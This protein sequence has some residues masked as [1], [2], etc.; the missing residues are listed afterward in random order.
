MVARFHYDDIVYQ[1]LLTDELPSKEEGEVSSHI[2]HCEACQA[3]LEVVSESGI[4]WDDVREFLQPGDSPTAQLGSTIGEPSQAAIDE[5]AGFNFLQ[6]SDDASSLGRFGR[7]EITE[8]LGRGGMGVVMRG[9]DPALNRHSAIKVLAPELASHAAA[10]SR[11]SREAKSAAAVVHE[12]VVP[13][14]TVDEAQGLPYLV[15]PVVEGQSLEKRVAEQGPMQVN[16][17]LRI[18]M[19]VASGLAAAHAQGLVHRD[20][21]PANIL[22]ENGVERVM[23]TDFGLARAADD[24]SMTRSG[25]IA[26]TPQYMSPEQARG[27]EIDHRSDLFSLGCVMYYMCIG[28]SPFRAETT[29]GVLHRIVNDP[30]RPIRSINPDVPAWLQTIIERLLSKDV[31]DRFQTAEEVEKLLGAW[32]AHRQQPEKVEAPA[33][34]SATRSRPSSLVGKCLTTA[35]LLTLAMLAGVVIVLELRKGTLTIESEQADL[36]I[37]IM[38]G[39]KV[40]RTMI[41]RRGGNSTRIAA[42]EYVVEIE[43]E[44]TDLVVDGSVVTLS[45]GGQQLV[46]IRHTTT[47]SESDHSADEIAEGSRPR[48]AGSVLSVG[49]TDN[50]VQ[51]L[52]A[53]PK[54][55]SFFLRN[56]TPLGV[57]ANGTLIGTSP[58]RHNFPSKSM[59]SLLAF[60]PTNPAERVYLMLEIRPLTGMT[61]PYVMHN[62]IPV[63]ITHEDIEQFQAGTAVLKVVYLADPERGST[64]LTGV[65][66]L[67]STHLDPGVD[68]L[69]EADRRGAVLAVL[70]FVGHTKSPP[71][72]N[73]PTVTNQT[74]LIEQV[75][76]FNNE[77][78]KQVPKHGQPLLTVEEMLASMSWALLV[79]K[80]L[81][82]QEREGFQRIVRDRKWPTSWTVVGGPTSLGKPG[83]DNRQGGGWEI[84]ICDEEKVVHVVRTRY[85]TPA[86]PD[87]TDAS[88]ENVEDPDAM[89]LAAAI[90][91]F[92]QSHY[93]LDGKPQ[94]PLTEDEVVAAIQQWKHRR[95]EAPVTNADFSK[96]QKIAETRSMPKEA[97]FEVIGH[98]GQSD[99]TT[100]SIWSVRIVMPD[101][102]PEGWT[103]AF[104]I[105]KQFISMTTSDESEIR[106]GTAGKNG[107]QAGVRLSPAN[108]EYA[109]GQ[110][111][112]VTFFYR[113]ISGQ[114]REGALPLLRINSTTEVIA[115]SGER[116]SSIDYDDTTPAGFSKTTFGARSVAIAGVPIVIR[117]PEDANSTLASDLITGDGA[118]IIFAK[119]G[120]SCRVRFTVPNQAAN[121]DEKLKTGYISFKVSQLSRR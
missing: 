5:D 116:I 103:Y 111:I 42:G 58:C 100:Y 10:R 72:T 35:A 1:Q 108:E 34:P 23:I 80:D 51:I 114:P 39:D 95:N 96:F 56:G 84:C 120:Q 40:A 65:E 118:T 87:H 115:L 71:R 68:A 17:V 81:T 107:M 54:N 33:Y 82:Q 75:R 70:R 47:S 101:S 15:M 94:P 76:S 50:K 27:A 11:F 67:V 109:M 55:W 14:Q 66:S 26:G 2:E 41:V 73:I 117:R 98:F 53:R 119:P 113:N 32:L 44:H 49:A 102:E 104:E 79:A 106:W 69:A 12:H 13:I 25:V 89:P 29:M 78:E 83:A 99:G 22:L 7:Y 62:A 18:G 92:N 24:A 57:T 74:S 97:K 45:R 52:F 61:R 38:K 110:P 46:T 20:V 86:Q 90:H 36:P 16:E 85:L 31:N 4:S 43:G 59:H 8:I 77:Q 63:Q 21:K 28:H 19:Q 112:K 30:P 121:S 91:S 9:Y 88:E 105:R 3:K 60:D 64:A 93:K 6:P 48:D 37:R